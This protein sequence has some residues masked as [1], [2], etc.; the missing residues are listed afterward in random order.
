MVRSKKDVQAKK[1]VKRKG[2]EDNGPYKWTEGETCHTVVYHCDGDKPEISY[3]PSCRL[4]PVVKFILSEGDEG[5]IS[6]SMDDDDEVADQIF[7]LSQTKFEELVNGDKRS[8]KKKKANKER[9]D[10]EG[11]DE[12][13]EE[14][15]EENEEEEEDL[16]VETLMSHVSDWVAKVNKKYDLIPNVPVVHGGNIMITQ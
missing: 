5:E 7:F 8:N 13:N 16:H 15:E 14:G 12:D 2:A 11:E 9:D 4:D 6:W 10:E 3:V 1:G